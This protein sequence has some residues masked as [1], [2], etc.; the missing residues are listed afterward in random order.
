M[1]L[2]SF[3]VGGSLYYAHDLEKVAGRAVIPFKDGRF[4]AGADT[5]LYVVWQEIAARCRPGTVYASFY[6]F[7]TT[8]LN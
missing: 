4:C 2:I 6:L 7:S 5:R 3:P 8:P 1:M